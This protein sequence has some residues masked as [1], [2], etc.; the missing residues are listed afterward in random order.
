M[1]SG[2][3]ILTLPKIEVYNYE[4]PGIAGVPMDAGYD[5]NYY[6][7]NTTGSFQSVKPEQ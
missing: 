6:Y 2:R 5:G 4:L 7:D 3:C 1:L